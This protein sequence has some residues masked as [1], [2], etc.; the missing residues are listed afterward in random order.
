LERKHLIFIHGLE[1]SGQGY[2][3]TLFREIFPEI[4]TPDFSGSLHRRMAHLQAIL[5]TKNQWTLIGSSF[6][7]IMATLFCRDF[8]DHVR[9][10]IL[11]APALVWPDIL[12][13]SAW[14]ISIP[15]QI[16]HGLDDPI[17]PIE[18]VRKIAEKHF[19]NLSFYSVDDDH[20]LHKT[21]HEIDWPKLVGIS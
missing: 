12:W 18:T 5:I 2:K 4:L 17:I 16:Y 14:Q 8:P 7:G 15:T 21:V 9:K 6:G 3:A 13:D 11:L 20:G 19:E 10:L 1:G